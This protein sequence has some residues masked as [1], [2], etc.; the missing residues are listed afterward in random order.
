[1][2]SLQNLAALT[3]FKRATRKNIKT[4]VKAPELVG[5]LG[6]N[7]TAQLQTLR[8]LLKFLDL[9]VVYTKASNEYTNATRLHKGESRLA[10]ARRTRINS[11]KKKVNNISVKATQLRNKIGLHIYRN[12]VPFNNSTL[13]NAVRRISLL[14]NE[15]NNREKLFRNLQALYARNGSNIK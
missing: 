8:R 13:R 10:P 12:T 4:I 5:A 1:M 14:R 2:S 7:R 15:G 11:A 3:V 6:P 9:Y